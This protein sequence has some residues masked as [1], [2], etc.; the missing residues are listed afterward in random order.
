MAA[1][2]Y[3]SLYRLGNGLRNVGRWRINRNDCRQ[4]ADPTTTAL[5]SGWIT[6]PLA[7]AKQSSPKP[8]V[9]LPPLPKPTSK[10]AGGVVSRDTDHRREAS[11]DPGGGDLAVTLNGDPQSF[12]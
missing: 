9:T 6:T 8:V 12:V 1:E 5:S 2:A 4:L 11:G 7:R 10:D 3:G